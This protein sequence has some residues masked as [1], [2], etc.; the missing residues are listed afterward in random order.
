M[1]KFQRIFITIFVLSL[2]LFLFNCGDSGSN[3]SSLPPD[4]PIFSISSLTNS[5]GNYIISWNISSR[6]TNYILEESNSSSF[7]NSN[8]VYDGSSISEII[9]GK[10]NGIYYYR[11]KA[12]NSVGESEWSNFISISVSINYIKDNIVLTKGTQQYIL[13]DMSDGF[14]ILVK[15]LGLC[16]FVLKVL[17]LKIMLF[18]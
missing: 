4:P 9:R 8:I 7:N 12:T 11:V 16:Q 18:I 10:S 13:S 2:F 3:S 5:N 17:I 14:F 1:N 15:I 6:A